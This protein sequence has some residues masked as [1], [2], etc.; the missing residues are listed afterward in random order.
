MRNRTVNGF[1]AEVNDISIRGIIFDKDGTLIKFDDFWRPVTE[2]AVTYIIRRLN[3]SENIKNE[4]MAAAGIDEGINGLICRG[5]YAQVAA[6]FESVLKKHG[7]AA[8]KLDALTFEAFESSREC[9]KVV[10]ACENI[11]GL[12][13]ELKRRGMS[14]FLVTTDCS[15]I[16]EKCLDEL[17]IKEYFDEVYTDDGVL[18]SKPDPYYINEIIKKY[19]FNRNELLM[20]GDTVTDMEFAKNGKISAVGVAGDC[21]GRRVLENYTGAV[22][23][24]ISQLT[25]L[26]DVL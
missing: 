24:N 18:P 19:G 11:K 14:I 3:V 17:G 22:V 21:D 10:A 8:D 7:E 20:V 16:T 12:L 2:Q 13:E 5:T 1:A 4:L 9:G 15:E 25:K 26:L 23:G 6:S